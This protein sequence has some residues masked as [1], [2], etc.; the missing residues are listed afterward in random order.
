M[1]PLNLWDWPNTKFPLFLSPFSPTPP[2]LP[3]SLPSFLKCYLSDFG[4]RVHDLHKIG[5]FLYYSLF[6][7]QIAYYGNYL[8]KKFKC[9]CIKHSGSCQLFLY[10]H[11]IILANFFFEIY[12]SAPD[13]VCEI[14][15]IEYDKIL[16]LSTV[17]VVI[18]YF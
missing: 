18:S 4:F 13:C 16:V 17:F 14:D 11:I 9:N 7:K 12:V 1:L 5:N 8:S 3:C 2:P 6:L 15:C 10:R